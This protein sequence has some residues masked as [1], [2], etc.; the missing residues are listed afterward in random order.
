LRLCRSE[1]TPVTAQDGAV[2][3]LQGSKT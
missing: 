3:I 1:S 2:M